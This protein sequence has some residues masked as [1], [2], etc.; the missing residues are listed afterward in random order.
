MKHY[1]FTAVCLLACLLTAGC[2]KNDPGYNAG[3]D[4]QI[5]LL[6]TRATKAEISYIPNDNQTYYFAHTM[7]S[8]TLAGMTDSEI[9]EEIRILLNRWYDF[10]IKDMADISIVDFCSSFLYQGPQQLKEYSLVAGTD[11]TT[12]VAQI[13]PQTREVMGDLHKQEFRTRAV[14][15]SACTFDLERNGDILSILPSVPDE[16]Y[17]FEYILS[18][19]LLDWDSAYEFAELTIDMLEE[20]GFMPYATVQGRRDLDLSQAED[21]LPDEEYTLV[22]VPY[23][24]EITAYATTF[25][26]TK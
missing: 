4:V 16:K 21:I 13:N 22:I 20:Y 8:A 18:E 5:S 25:T 6:S 10:V 24:G 9:K 17:W 11:Y 2:K 23:N 7:G 26:F 1:A 15:P 14:T 19:D 12:L 3:F